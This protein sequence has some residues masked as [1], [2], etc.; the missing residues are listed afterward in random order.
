M[1]VEQ[2]IACW[3]EILRQRRTVQEAV[4]ILLCKERCDDAMSWPFRPSSLGVDSLEVLEQNLEI[5]RTF[6][7][8]TDAERTDI[9]ARSKP[10]ATGQFE[11][12]KSTHRFEGGEGRVAHSYPLAS[13]ESAAD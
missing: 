10:Y 1:C 12:F 6:T 7:P 5:A 9:L 8:L 3:D 4:S 11:E 2:G 13:L